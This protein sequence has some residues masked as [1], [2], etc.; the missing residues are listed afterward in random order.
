M[1]DVLATFVHRDFWGGTIC[2]VA[3]GDGARTRDKALVTCPKCSAARESMEHILAV[4]VA[5]ALEEH[6]S[7][8]EREIARLRAALRSLA[9][10]IDA[11]KA[12][13]FGHLYATVDALAVHA[14]SEAEPR[15]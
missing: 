1:N 13:H 4:E 10:A 6:L 5:N 7:A 15:E 8:D 14:R 11:L 9:T 2:G 3:A 12:V